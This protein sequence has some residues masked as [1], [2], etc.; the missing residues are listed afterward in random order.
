MLWM[1]MYVDMGIQAG[2]FTPGRS[3]NIFGDSRRHLS[4]PPFSVAST[5]CGI[6]K[7]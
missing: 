4:F 3:L 5:V 2:K 7:E 1:W 6:L